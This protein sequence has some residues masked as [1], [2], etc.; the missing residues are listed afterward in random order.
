M[1]KIH[2]LSGEMEVF[3]WSEE[4]ERETKFARVGAGVGEAGLPLPTERQEKLEG[5]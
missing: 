3:T 4:S 1:M 2:H 5:D